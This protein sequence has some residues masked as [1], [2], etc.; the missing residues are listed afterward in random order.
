[1]D[2]SWLYRFV[3]ILHPTEDRLLGTGFRLSES[4]ALTAFHVVKGHEA[5]RVADVKKGNEAE[6][7]AWIAR[8]AEVVWPPSEA[9]ESMKSLDVALLKTEI[10]DQIEPW[11]RFQTTRLGQETSWLSYGYPRSSVKPSDRKV[12]KGT[13]SEMLNGEQRFGITV[14]EGLADSVEAWKGISGSPIVLDTGDPARRILLG[15]LRSAPEDFGVS[16][17]DG[18]PMP[19]LWAAEGFQQALA[20]P[21]ATRADPEVFIELVSREMEG[22]DPSH[23]GIYHRSWG[24]E[25]PTEASLARA[26]C[27]GTPPHETANALEKAGRDLFAAGE[28][29]QARRLVEFALVAMVASL[30]CHH[31]TDLPGR[32]SVDVP[33]PCRT[34]FAAELLTAAIDV[35]GAS[36]GPPPDAAHPPPAL[37]SASAHQFEAGLDPTGAQATID[38]ANDLTGR[39]GAHLTT[40]SS[41]DGD[42]VLSKLVQFATRSIPGR[43]IAFDRSKEAEFQQGESTEDCRK[44]F[45]EVVGEFIE[46]VAKDGRRAYFV[47][48]P[49]DSRHEKIFEGLRKALPGLRLAALSE[50]HRSSKEEREINGALQSLLKSYYEIQEKTL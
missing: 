37:F 45:F 8:P 11:T 22:L 49:K 36:F 46:R 14:R 32:E 6:E 10:A 35:K 24:Q 5:P 40:S 13:A 50:N 43:P 28:V 19:A 30:A 18:V 4:R 25:A 21:E 1:M 17:C 29:H 39:L 31:P 27:K 7:E 34:P 12:L 20:L 15:V 26:I 38:L 23:L 42:E 33:L 41:G 3:M 16:R 9:T 2:Q 47:G 48:D 44:F